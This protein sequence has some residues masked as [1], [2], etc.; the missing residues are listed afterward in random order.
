MNKFYGLF[1]LN[2]QNSVRYHDLT[3]W[4]DHHR[5]TKQSQL[6]RVRKFYTK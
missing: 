5:A 6:E 1:K 3:R 4:T 2:D